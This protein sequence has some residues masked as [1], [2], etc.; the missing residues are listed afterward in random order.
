MLPAGLLRRELEIRLRQISMATRKELLAAVITRY[1]TASTA[2][3][4]RILDEFTAVT[5]YH[6]KHAI[7]LLNADAPL[8]RS[9]TP[10]TPLYDEAVQQALIVLWE[11][12]R[13]Q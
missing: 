9:R 6:R 10:R 5:G 3:K 4:V 13:T 11:A 12:S 8:A 2:E 7:R 1:A